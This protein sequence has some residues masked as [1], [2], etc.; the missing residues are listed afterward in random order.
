MAFSED[1]SPWL[2]MK[3]SRAWIEENVRWKD[4]GT[5][6]RL[7]RL[8]KQGPTSIVLYDVDSEV[9]VSAFMPHTHP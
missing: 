7:G 1:L 4:F 5:G 2:T 6:V 3:Y 8:A 9:E